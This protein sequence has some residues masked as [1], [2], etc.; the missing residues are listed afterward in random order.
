MYVF[1]NVTI[2]CTG[3]LTSVNVTGAT[4]VGDEEPQLQIWRMGS[5]NSVPNTYI[6]KHLIPLVPGQSSQCC[7]TSS[8]EANCDYGVEAGD[9]VGVQLPQLE[10]SSFLIHFSRHEIPAYILQC[11]IT[12][13]DLGHGNQETIGFPLISM[14]IGKA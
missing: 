7:S 1:P 4:G 10:E 13:F 14:R 11:N 9:I 3:K 5:T 8:T 12:N 2:N 6:L